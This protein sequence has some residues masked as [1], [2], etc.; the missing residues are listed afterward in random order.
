MFVVA[1]PVLGIVI[2]PA[3]MH[4]PTCTPSEITASATLRRATSGVVGVVEMRGEHCSIPMY[5]GPSALVDADWRRLDVPVAPA[6]ALTGQNVRP[7]LTF[8]AGEGAWGF[9]WTGSWCGPAPAGVVL[10]LTGDAQAP[11]DA[12][13]ALTVPIT[14]PA[15]TCDGASDSTLVRGAAG[16][17]G[18]AV[19]PPPAAW[20]SLTAALHAPTSP[21]YGSNVS[22]TLTNDSDT[23]VP[24]DPCP[25]F[26]LAVD[27]RYSDGSTTAADFGLLPCGAGTS[28]PAHGHLDLSLAPLPL[29]D[30][31][32]RTPVA[33]TMT[34]ALA[35]GV[36]ASAELR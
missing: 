24:L 3:P 13:P 14:G 2:G 15:P 28:V 33:A 6:S 25:R 7:D 16:R 26:S 11:A 8:A 18:E 20:T 22:V 5:P 27:Y 35:G 19:L 12:T 21:P 10:P 30:D 34:F 9:A 23:D 36:R 29:G 4:Q 31:D 1:S 32:S 17:I